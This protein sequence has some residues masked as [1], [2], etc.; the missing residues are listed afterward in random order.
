[1]PFII[2]KVKKILSIYYNEPHYLPHPYIPNPP[3]HFLPLNSQP[4][5]P[6]KLNQTAMVFR[7]INPTHMV[8]DHHPQ[9]LHFLHLTQLTQ[10]PIQLPNHYPIIQN[11]LELVYS[12]D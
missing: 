12:R 9:V 8:Q 3:P 4:L 7:V 6:P 1:V 5:G 10:S 11:L 2:F